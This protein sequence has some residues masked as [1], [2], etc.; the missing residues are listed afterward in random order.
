MARE[1]THMGGP[2]DAEARAR[3]KAKNARNAQR[4][5]QAARPGCWAIA[6]QRQRDAGMRYPTGCGHRGHG[7][8]PRRTV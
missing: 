8:I 6:A 2:L 7:F 4:G 5:G 1:G 3:R